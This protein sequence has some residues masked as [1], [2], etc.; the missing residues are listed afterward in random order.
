MA[1][2]LNNVTL[3]GN[4]GKDPEFMGEDDKGARFSLATSESW[5]DKQT[6]DRQEKVEWHRIVCWNKG[7]TGI[8]K[9]Y[10]KKG[11]KLYIQGKLVTRK[12]TDNNDIER[13]TTEVV[14]GPYN[15]TLLLLGPKE[16][17][18][19]QE[20]ADDGDPRAKRQPESDDDDEIPF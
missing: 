11:S 8:I 6:G 18:D 17:G 14:L 4:V 3:I 19:A 15:A 1:Q 16:G 7:L 13:Y 9:K 12:W 20:P 5:T 2:G 10:V